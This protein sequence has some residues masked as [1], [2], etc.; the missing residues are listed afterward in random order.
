[1][2]IFSVYNHSNTDNKHTHDQVK[3]YL[4][5]KAIAFTECLGSWKGIQEYSIAVGDQHRETVE[6]ICDTFLQEAFLYVNDRGFA[7]FTYSHGEVVGAGKFTAVR[8]G[9]QASLEGYTVINGIT[10]TIK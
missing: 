5:S 1:M 8:E 2:L 9:D 4:R 3:A 6:I 10:Y 7:S